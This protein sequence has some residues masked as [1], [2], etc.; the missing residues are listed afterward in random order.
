MINVSENVGDDC[1]PQ[2]AYLSN[3]DTVFVILV[4]EHTENGKTDIWM[5]KDIFSPIIS[6][7]P[8][9]FGDENLFELIQN[10]PNP[11]NPVTTIEYSIQA[12]VKSK[13]ANEASGFSLRYITLNIYDILGR[14]V[15]RLVNENK[16]PG[17]YSVEF[18]G[19]NLSSG[20]YYYKLTAGNFSKIKKMILIK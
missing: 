16:E 12:K 18:D 20:I 17:N 6:D 7:V 9:D 14:E 2:V 19:G 13:K 3:A 1:K 10:Y 11:F 4:W 5:T 8:N 15:A